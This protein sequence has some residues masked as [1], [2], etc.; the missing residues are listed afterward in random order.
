MRQNEASV[1]KEIAM[2]S[3]TSMNP[4][5]ELGPKLE[6]LRDVV[7]TLNLEHVHLIVSLLVFAKNPK[8]PSFEG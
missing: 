2:K 1:N 3:L 4:L 5:Q 6:I 7:E 8:C